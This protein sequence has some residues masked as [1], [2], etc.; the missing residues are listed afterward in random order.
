MGNDAIDLCQLLEQAG[1]RPQVAQ[2]S[3]ERVWVK[4]LCADSRQVQAGE[5]FLGM[6]GSRVDGGEFVRAALTGGAVAALISQEAWKK[7]GGAV[8]YT[9]LTMP[10]IYSV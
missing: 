10:T 2:G 9:H 7:V 4:G 6:P 5:L 3:L 8:S 1:I